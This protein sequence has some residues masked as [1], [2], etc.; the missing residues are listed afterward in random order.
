MSPIPLVLLLNSGLG[1]LTNANCAR[2]VQISV[3]V[4]PAA[5][6]LGEYQPLV[7]HEAY[8]ARHGA[9]QCSST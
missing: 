8:S 1:W 9:D 3:A 4:H 5:A 2:E 7:I 6:K